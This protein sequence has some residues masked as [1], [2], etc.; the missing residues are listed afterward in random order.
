[1]GAGALKPIT[2]DDALDILGYEQPFE[3]IPFGSF[4]GNDTLGRWFLAI[5]EHYGV[6]GSFCMTVKFQGKNKSEGNGLD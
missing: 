4:T 3:E 2:V 5:N 1:M 6:K